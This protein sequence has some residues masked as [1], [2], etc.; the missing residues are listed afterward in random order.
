MMYLKRWKK[1]VNRISLARG[2]YLGYAKRWFE[3]LYLMI[4]ME[5]G[6]EDILKENTV[7]YIGFSY[8]SS[9]VT[10]SDEEVLEKQ[11]SG[12]VFDNVENPYLEKSECGWTIDPFPHHS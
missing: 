3:K 7:D 1:T 11:T 10:S 2:A 8:Y 5:Q 12:D 9:R 6:D 4:D